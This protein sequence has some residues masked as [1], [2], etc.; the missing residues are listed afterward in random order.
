VNF[1]LRRRLF[2]PGAWLAAVLAAALTPPGALAQQPA[3]SSGAPAWSTALEAF[4]E[5]LARDVSDDDIGGLVAGVAV[6]GDL[7]WAGAFGWADRDLRIPM[8]TATVSRTGSIS[9]P[10]TAFLLMR[11]VD[12]GLVRLDDPV[13]RHLP[14]LRELDDPDG[15]VEH[16]TFR[17]L[18][19]HQGGLIREPRLQGAATG[20]IEEWEQQ[21]L[22]SIPTTSFAQPPGT[23]ALYSNIGY[24]ILG[25]A[26]SRAA[27]RPFMEL[28]EDEV[29]RPL[30]MTGSTFVVDHELSPR[31]AAGYVRGRDGGVD[32]S[33]PAREHAGRGYKV[34]NGG[35]Y[36]TVGDLARLAGAVTGTPGL[37]VLSEASRSELLTIQPPGGPDRGYGVGFSI[38]VD[39]DR[40]RLVSHGG[41]VAG[42]TA[43][44]V[45]DPDT[46]I[47]VILLR[48]YGG[49]ATNLG[50]TA[51]RLLRELA[52]AGLSGN[53]PGSTPVSTPG[54][55]REPTCR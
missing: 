51:S 23:A 49:G 43:H 26:L 31:L 52:T 29:F 17:L 35:I 42:Y 12:Q 6:D 1:C 15:H 47:S 45:F 54:V 2:L 37:R 21:V 33:S 3:P 9:K 13:V 27:D 55:I 36:S 8:G 7:I 11:L 40:R 46:G 18:A 22:R 28:V 4:S 50:A 5:A 44:M 53:V 25:L 39:D 32:G 10:V 38:R 19:S 41:A 14:E 30:G 20:P 24:G 48:N 16:M 34:P